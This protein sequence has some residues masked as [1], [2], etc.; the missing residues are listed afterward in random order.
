[1]SREPF[2]VVAVCTY[3]GKNRIQRLIK[4]LK[5]IDYPNY[6]III[7]DNNSS[8]GTVELI[9]SNEEL[10]VIIEERQG[11]SYARNKAIDWCDSSVDY[12]AFLDDDEEVDPDWIKRMLEVF[13]TDRRIVVVGGPYLPV[14]EV[15]KSDWMIKDFFAYRDD[16]KGIEIA[17]YTNIV[18]GNFMV[19]FKILKERDV[20]F[21]TKLGYNG[22]LLLSGEDVD[23][24]KALV[25]EGDL[26][27]FTE[28]AHVRHY[29]NKDKLT[30]KWLSKR[31][32]SEGITQWYKYGTKDF[33]HSLLHLPLN[34][35]TFM[36]SLFTFNVSIMGKRFFKIVHCLGVISGPF[37]IS[38]KK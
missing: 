34:T 3:N 24:I 16:F 22:S 28:F 6:K 32:Y 11:L 23:F 9:N 25:Q 10:T 1:M 21:N 4:S 5:K 37:L 19:D 29:I 7:V 26:C 33:F 8:D 2:V 18:G 17:K 31:V 38:R 35:V 13:L 27:G 36:C 20:K 14:Y 30:I 12:L 15:K